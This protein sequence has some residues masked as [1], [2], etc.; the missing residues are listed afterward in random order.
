[1]QAQDSGF[2]AARIALAAELCGSNSL[3]S[4]DRVFEIEVEQVQKLTRA[5]KSIHRVDGHWFPHV[6]DLFVP[7]DKL[8]TQMQGMVQDQLGIM[9]LNRSQ[10]RAAA[11][12]TS[13]KGALRVSALTG[14]APASEAELAGLPLRQKDAATIRRYMAG[15]VTRDVAEHALLSS[16]ADLPTLAR[17]IRNGNDMSLKLA[18]ILRRPAADFT[19]KAHVA[20]ERISLARRTALARHPQFER[21]MDWNAMRHVLLQDFI[22]KQVRQ[23]GELPARSIDE[24]ETFCPGMSTATHMLFLQFKKAAQGGRGPLVPSDF[25]DCL[26]TIYAPYVS[27]FRA[28]KRTTP[29][30]S[31]I[32][33]RWGTT[34][35]QRIEEVPGLIRARLAT[36]GTS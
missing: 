17:W 2:A 3:A 36:N 20:L 9:K 33:R 34:V 13:R 21:Q 8:R 27:I 32:I 28:D 19:A 1:V 31:P 22:V 26:H 16:L 15:Q 11:A 10:R 12:Q 35:T 23:R 14:L 18:P 30:V 7:A 24:F 6:S 29:D 25:A 4:V 5:E